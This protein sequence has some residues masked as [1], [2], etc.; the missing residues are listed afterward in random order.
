M[1][2]TESARERKL[3]RENSKQLISPPLS[4]HEDCSS[5]MSLTQIPRL[6]T[7]CPVATVEQ[8]SPSSAYEKLI[9]NAFT[10]P[11]PKVNEEQQKPNCDIMQML[12]NAQFKFNQSESSQLTITNA[13]INSSPSKLFS[14]LF[15]KPA[16]S[17]NSQR[18]F[19]VSSNTSLCLS[20]SPSTSST[21]TGYSTNSE[22]IKVINP[23]IQKL[24]V[25][26][27]QH[28]ITTLVAQTAPSASTKTL[29]EIESGF[30]TSAHASTSHDL[31]SEELKRKL[32]IKSSKGKLS[33]L[34][35]KH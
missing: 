7:P 30:M 18:Q 22:S 5:R 1:D 35:K 26:Q 2:L 4:S 6:I 14:D 23:M 20:S 9:S 17:D 34:L 11:T 12:T 29:D 10:S 31:L 13:N 28:P 33:N 32:N 25:P 24:L 19:P 27:K 8:K 15:T 21:S 16:A 3:K